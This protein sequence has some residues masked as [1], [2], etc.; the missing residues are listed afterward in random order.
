M[1]AHF[2]YTRTVAPYSHDIQAANYRWRLAEASV[3]VKRTGS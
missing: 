2:A 1:T 3:T